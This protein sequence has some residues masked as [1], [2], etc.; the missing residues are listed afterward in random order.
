MECNVCILN[1]DNEK[2]MKKAHRLIYL[3]RDPRDGIII[4]STALRRNID[5]TVYEENRRRKK[6]VVV[7]RRRIWWAE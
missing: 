5:Y 7:R 2:T 3:L 1:F 4:T 6:R